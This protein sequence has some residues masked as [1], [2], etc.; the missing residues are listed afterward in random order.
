MPTY[1]F[2]AKD[3]EDIAEHYF[4]LEEMPRYGDEVE[5]EGR[6]WVRIFEGSSASVRMEPITTARS[7]PR[8]GDPRDPGAPRYDRRGNAV[9][10]TSEEKASYAKAYEQHN[11]EKCHYERTSSQGAFK[12]DDA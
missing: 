5:I 7:M 9:L 2:K 11:H 10:V 1:V 8:R 3:G 6:T 4:P 12:D